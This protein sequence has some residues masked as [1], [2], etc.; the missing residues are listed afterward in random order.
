[1]L[2]SLNV[3][4]SSRIRSRRMLVL[5]RQSSG[6]AAGSCLWIVFQSCGKLSRRRVE[7]MISRSTRSSCCL[8]ICTRSGAS[9]R[10]TPIFHP[11]AADQNS[12]CQSAAE[13]RAADRR[14]RR[15]QRTRH[16][17]APILG[18]LDPRRSRLHPPCGILLYQSAEAPACRASARLAAFVV[19]SRRPRR[20]VSTGL[21]WRY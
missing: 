18:A 4:L 5:H 1:M 9:R 2:Y 11:L 16:L 21:G 7:T 17:A 13:T 10:A 12:L 6:S 8:T 3:E 19:S 15:T 20:I 14:S